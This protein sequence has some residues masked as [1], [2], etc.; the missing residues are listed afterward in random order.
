MD[1][2]LIAGRHRLQRRSPNAEGRAMQSC[3]ARWVMVMLFV[4]AVPTAP[5]LAQVPGHLQIKIVKA[6]L[7]AG[8][9]V[10][11]G[12][13]S[14]RGRD[15]PFRVVGVSVGLTAGASVGR[16]EGWVT[17]IHK[18]SDFAGTYRSVGGGGAVV[19]GAGA[20]HLRNE[21]GVVIELRG[22]RAG[23]E[24]AANLS[25]IRILLQ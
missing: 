14:Y 25:R 24:F 9:G 8:G 12:V 15:Y 22:P 6:G 21:N 20:T 18:L 23:M 13:L 1:I 2:G 7:V 5:S 4:F 16:L 3:A 19:G 17:G 11:H 10:G